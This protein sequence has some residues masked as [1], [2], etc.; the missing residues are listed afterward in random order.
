MGQS[1]QVEL[2]E[3]QDA[4]LNVLI[5]I[6]FSN[7]QLV[8]TIRMNKGHTGIQCQLLDDAH[9]NPYYFPMTL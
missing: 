5:S 6:S 2:K 3:D 1:L 7:A 8:C 4:M 9:L